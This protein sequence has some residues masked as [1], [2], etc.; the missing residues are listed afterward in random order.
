MHIN[1]AT[2]IRE[3]GF[4]SELSLFEE[5]EKSLI[6]AEQKRIDKMICISD[7]EKVELIDIK[8]NKSFNTNVEELI[9]SMG[10]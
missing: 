9:N 1:F 3:K 6:Y 8:T 4:I 10:E 7:D 5:K 2:R